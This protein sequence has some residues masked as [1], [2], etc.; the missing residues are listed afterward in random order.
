MQKRVGFVPTDR[1]IG[2]ERGFLKISFYSSAD[3]SS[4]V[5]EK[6]FRGLTVS[7]EVF[8]IEGEIILR[9]FRAYCPVFAR[10]KFAFCARNPRGEKT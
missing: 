4:R 6:N 1:T 2:N 3:R 9:G 5:R 8:G 10:A 7:A